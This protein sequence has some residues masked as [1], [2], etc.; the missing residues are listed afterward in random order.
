MLLLEKLRQKLNDGGRAAAVAAIAVIVIGVLVLF[1]AARS[2]FGPSSAAVHNGE[3]VY[4]CSES[5][6][7]FTYSPTPGAKLFPVR[8]PYSGKDTGYPAQLCYWTADGKIK[9]DPTPVLMNSYIGKKGPTFCPDC[10][11]LVPVNNPVVTDGAPP[12]PTRDEYYARRKAHK[13]VAS[14]DGEDE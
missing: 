7:T 14:D 3:R 13:P 2:S 4:I 8:S 9:K 6:K 10:N 5:G 12:P 1:V 11:R